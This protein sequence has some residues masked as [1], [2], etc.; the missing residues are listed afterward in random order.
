MTD[1]PLYYTGKSPR[2]YKIANVS[3]TVWTFSISKDGDI[4]YYAV[5]NK[6]YRL[7]NLLTSQDSSTLQ[8]DENGYALQNTLIKSFSGNI[9][10]I[11]ID[12]AD[13]NRI[14][15]TLGGFSSSYSHVYYSQNATA[16]SPTFVSKRGDLPTTLPVY[17]ALIPMQ[18]PN[19]V[20]IGTEYGIMATEN[21]SSASPTWAKQNTGIDDPVPV[22]MLRQQIYQ[23]PWMLAGRW[24]QGVFVPMVYPGIYNYGEIYA[25]THGRGLFK[26]KGYVGFR[27]IDK[28]NGKL[29][30]SEIK[31]YPNPVNTIANVEFETAA[32]GSVSAKIYDVNGRFVKNVNFGTLPAGKQIQKIDVSGLKTGIYI[33]RIISGNQSKT[34]KFIVK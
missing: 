20:I 12:P 1:Q 33:I 19:T 11:A 13:A 31:L 24:D 2:W 10:S 22:F 17:A 14:I 21:I 7:S 8:F 4:L 15:V 30:K 9:S 5:N 18:N 6:L 29:F 27:E 26:C 28:G 25:A 23:Q 34:S 3:G 16:A 32:R